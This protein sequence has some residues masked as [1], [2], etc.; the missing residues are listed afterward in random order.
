MDRASPSRAQR[1]RIAEETLIILEHGA[2]RAGGGQHISIQTDLATAK[3]G[4]RLYTPAQREELLQRAR[5]RLQKP[6]CQHATCFEVTNETTLHAAR[7]LLDA[8]PD[9]RIAALNFASA[10][11]PGGGFLGGSQAQEESLARASG[12]YTCLLRF[13]VMYEIN[14]AER[15]CLYT[16]HLIYSPDVPVFRGDE[17]ELLD[18]PYRLS[19]LTAPAVNA[20]VVR[21]REPV[22]RDRIES[23]MRSRME[24]L[25]A[26]AVVHQHDVLVLGAWGCGVFRNDPNEVARWF[27]EHLLTGSYKSAFRRV[28]FAVLDHSHD[29]TMIRPFQQQFSIIQA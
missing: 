6:G 27:A 3:S 18:Q 8:E 25:L 20:G 19:F 4:S 1:K 28:V 15:S 12:L 9:L 17:D 11:H 26:A 5:E 14:Q 29:G 13:P 7:R 23:V 16:D 22:N 2:Y 10:R 21:S 24:L